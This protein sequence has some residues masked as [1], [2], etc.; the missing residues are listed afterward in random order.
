MIIKN[1]DLVELY[2]ETLAFGGEG[3]ARV[4]GFV[5]FVKGA[6]PNDRVIARIIKKKKD[7]ANAVIAAM[8]TTI[9]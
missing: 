1:N 3:I 2:V 8:L 4:D 5:V 6:I 9:P 7:Y